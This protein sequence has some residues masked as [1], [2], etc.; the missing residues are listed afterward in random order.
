MEASALYCY[1]MLSPGPVRT[2]KIP[3]MNVSERDKQ[4]LKTGAPNFEKQNFESIFNISKKN[5][6]VAGTEIF[7]WISNRT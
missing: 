4:N 5:I 2:Q 1:R 7:A 3:E 6:F